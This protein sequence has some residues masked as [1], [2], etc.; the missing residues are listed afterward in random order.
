MMP[1]IVLDPAGRYAAEAALARTASSRK[2]SRNAALIMFF[3]P[4][5]EDTHC[6]L[7]AVPATQTRNGIRHRI[8]LA[9][10][11]VVEMKVTMASG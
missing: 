9:L 5:N 1:V 3:D 11:S 8:E 10:T 7:D 6:G 4:L 2:I